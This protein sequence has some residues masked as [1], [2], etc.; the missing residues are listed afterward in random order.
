MRP[1]IPSRVAPSAETLYLSVGAAFLNGNPRSGGC[2]SS[3][4]SARICCAVPRPE[5]IK[6]SRRLRACPSAVIEQMFA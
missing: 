5:P 1:S 2:G 4:T 3:A 6:R